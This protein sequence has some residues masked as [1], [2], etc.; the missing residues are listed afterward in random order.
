MIK[1][2]PPNRRAS[3]SDRRHRCVAR[4]G[5]DHAK[6]RGKSPRHLSVGDAVRGTARPSRGLLH[7]DH[8]DSGCTQSGG[9]WAAPSWIGARSQC[10]RKTRPR[11]SASHWVTRFHGAPGPGRRTRRWMLHLDGSLLLKGQQQSLVPAPKPTPASK[12]LS[13]PMDSRID[14]RPGTAFSFSSGPTTPRSYA[15]SSQYER[16]RP[17]ACRTDADRVVGLHGR[18]PLARRTERVA[19][20]GASSADRTPSNPD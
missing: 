18:E 20:L 1:A 3:R 4:R 16:R 8:D 17:P 10:A 7:A 12:A 5:P 2:T 19:D 11:S 9:W 13:P 6:S 15:S 14:L